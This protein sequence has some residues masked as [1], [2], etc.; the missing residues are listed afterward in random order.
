MPRAALPFLL[1]CLPLAAQSVDAATAKLHPHLQA[2]LQAARP[3]DKLPVY[4]VLA[5]RLGYDHWF[6][7]VWSMPLA[8]R[9]ATV[10]RELQQH[11][12]TTQ[13]ILLDYLT[14]EQAAGNATAA[15]SNWLGNFIAV[16]ATPMVILTAATDA[17][18]A[19]VWFDHVPPREA[20]EDAAPAPT[21]VGPLPPPQ[22]AVS[23]PTALPPRLPG[24][25]PSA[26]FA[27]RVWAYGFEGQGVLV[28]NTDSGIDQS[29][30]YHTDLAANVWVNPGEIAGNLLDDDNNGFVD[31]VNGWNFGTNT[32]VLDDGG[33]HGTNTSGCIVA[34]GTFDGTTYGMAPQARLM[35]GALGGE[36][37][38]WAAL[39][40]GLLMGADVQTSSHS[41]KAYFNPP[42][43]YKMHRDIGVSTL[44]A[45][46]IRTNST[47]NDGSLCSSATNAA[48]R[49]LNISAPGNLPPPYLDPNQTLRGQLGGVVGVAAWNFTANALMSYSPCG[50]F[51]W[52]QA[53][54]LLHV[55]TY[56][57]ANWDAQHN[58]YPWTG[59]SQQGLLKPDV[60]APTST[61]T[62]AGSPSSYTTFSGT[63]NATPNACGVFTLWKSANPS[64]TPEDVGMIVHQTSRDRGS[65][66]G[67]ENGWGAGVIDA[68]AG[69]YRALCVHRAD[70]QPQWSITHSIGAGALQCSV[71]GVPNSLA[72]VVLGFSRGTS[73]VGP[74]TVG[75]TLP[76]ITLA[77]GLTDAQGDLQT[78][79]ATSPALVGLTIYTQ[80]LLQDSTWTNRILSSNVI[81][82]TFVP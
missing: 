22:P 18:I 23:A 15:H 70:G 49:P 45:G 58:D 16:E 55:P 81:G 65:V 33:G 25:G 14:A 27:D 46:M 24:N 80:A 2:L 74:V 9:R 79:L 67:K 47:S 32:N 19:E 78:S 50:P 61:R 53:D 1:A 42:P 40:Y 28:L 64:L 17:A 62:T 59:G 56:P 26:V 71:D 29:P 73:V 77:F 7:R 82:T 48:R 43:N 41:Y 57:S 37:S 72:A 5:D 30:G 44:A 36:S 10:L 54:V 75:V 51:A 4:F 68:E 8:E 21:F 52:N 69:L 39:Q 35:T 13:S 12:A 38:Q 63:S 20:V 60:A 31:D 11:A 66:A 34:N 3:G 76:V 6:P